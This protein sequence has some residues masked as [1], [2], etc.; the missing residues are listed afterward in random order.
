M[1]LPPLAVS[2]VGVRLYGILFPLEPTAD[3]H[4]YLL[5]LDEPVADAKALQIMKAVSQLAETGA[6]VHVTYVDV[7]E[8]AGGNLD[9]V[10]NDEGELEEVAPLQ[11][12]LT[13]FEI[14]NPSSLRRY[15]AAAIKLTNQTLEKRG[16][17]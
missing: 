8:D 4:Q 13:E 15:P 6:V 1:F 12:S 11:M 16:S 14:L 5:S 7:V 3:S 9:V 2:S 17:A 10:S